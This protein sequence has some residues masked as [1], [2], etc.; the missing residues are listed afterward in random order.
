[1]WLMNHF[2][3]PDNCLLQPQRDRGA[4]DEPPPW[5]EAV[6]AA[7]PPAASRSGWA[8]PRRSPEPRPALG[9]APAAG[10]A[11]AWWH[12]W[13]VTPPR[14]GLLTARCLQTAQASHRDKTSWQAGTVTLGILVTE[15]IGVLVAFFSTWEDNDAHF[16]WVHEHRFYDSSTYR[17]SLAGMYSSKISH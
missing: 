4:G 16:G 14:L 17:N 3:R 12:G 1:M 8:M 6:S 10:P 9:Q 13:W 7:V 11:G 5:Q 15:T 2:S